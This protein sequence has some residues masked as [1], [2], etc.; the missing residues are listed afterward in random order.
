MST[1]AKHLHGDRPAYLSACKAPDLFPS[2]CLT[3]KDKQNM[4]EQTQAVERI[5]G[6]DSHPESFTAAVVSG[7]TPAAAVIEKVFNKIAMAQLQSWAKRH[8]NLRDLIVLEASGNSF[9]VVRALK[10]VERQ[11]KVLESCQM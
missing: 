2:V 9:Q 11:A 7:P 1:G 8:T 3:E 6:L 10:A 4:N 5:I